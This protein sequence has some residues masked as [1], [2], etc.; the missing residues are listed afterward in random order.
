MSIRGHHPDYK[1]RHAL[2]VDRGVPCGNECGS[3]QPCPEMQ[4]SCFPRGLDHSM[5]GISQ[6][7]KGALETRPEQAISPSV[8]LYSHR[9]TLPSHFLAARMVSI[10]LAFLLKFWRFNL[11]SW[12]K[13]PQIFHQPIFHLQ[14]D[15]EARDILIS[16]PF[17]GYIVH[18]GKQIIIKP[19]CPCAFQASANMKFRDDM[20][21]R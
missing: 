8:S 3:L 15:F 20:N 18:V 9:Q 4:P 21:G 13:Q 16:V 1:P 7:L 17:H 11:H 10:Y 6:H 19:K 5:R 2:G 14:T 12:H